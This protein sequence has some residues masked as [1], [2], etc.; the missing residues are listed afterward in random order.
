MLWPGLL[1]R[2]TALERFWGPGFAES[3]PILI[4]V[5]EPV[6]YMPTHDFFDRY[7]SSHQGQFAN[8]LQ[9]MTQEMPLG[10]DEKL[11]WKDLR[12]VR[13]LGLATGDVYAAVRLTH[14]LDAQDRRSQLRIGQNYTFEDLRN[15]PAV[16]VGAYNN[17]WGIQLTWNLRYRF[18]DGNPRSLQL[19]DSAP[20]GQHWERTLDDQGQVVHDFGLVT[21]LLDSKTGQFTVTIGGIEADGTQAAAELITNPD[22]FKQVLHDA[23]P[24]WETK[25]MEAVIETTVTDMIASPPHVV[26]AYFW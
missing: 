16:L 6:V 10:P 14:F 18:K 22:Y 8:E 4:C 11:T 5:P 19:Y 17:K 12:S 13:D 15:S 9:R 2:K 3:Q 21:R 23:P 7:A 25:N 1:H 26:K 20:G 24:D